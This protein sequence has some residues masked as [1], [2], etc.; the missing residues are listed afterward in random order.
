M[1]LRGRTARRPGVVGRTSRPRY[2]WRAWEGANSNL[3]AGGQLAFV[4]NTVGVYPDL[5]VLG[6]LGDYTVRRIHGKIWAASE[7]GNEG[8]NHDGFFYGIGVIEDDAVAAG[9]FPD[10]RNDAFDWMAYGQV[11]VSLQGA[12]SALIHPTT[13]EVIDN[14]SMRKVNENHQSLVLVMDSF[15]TNQAIISVLTAGRFLVSHGQR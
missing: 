14:K 8:L 1:T 5:N 2:T 10:P 11:G 4:L 3:N 13:T 9:A 12:F 6:V 15:Q 7:L